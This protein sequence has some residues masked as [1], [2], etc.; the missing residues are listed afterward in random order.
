MIDRLWYHP[1]SECYFV[2]P[3]GEDP[4]DPLCVDVTG[5]EDHERA[6]QAE[7]V[8]PRA[9]TDLEAFKKDK[10]REKLIDNFKRN[11]FL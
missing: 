2:L 7:G 8:W 9:P 1:E 4:G 11:G 5:H 10:R 6:A 3:A